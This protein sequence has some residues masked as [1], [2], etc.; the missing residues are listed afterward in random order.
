MTPRQLAILQHS[1]GIDRYGQGEMYRDYF[2]AG[3]GDEATCR[4]LIALGYMINVAS[5]EI[6][7]DFNCRV[8]EAGKQAVRLE[9]PPP[10]KLTPSQQRYRRFLKMDTGYS[11]T[12]WLKIYGSRE[13]AQ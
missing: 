9:S 2:S 4:E 11:F 1:L 7:P 13:A 12:E 8:T 10:P 3:V 5:S 6:Y